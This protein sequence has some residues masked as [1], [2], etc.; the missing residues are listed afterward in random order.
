M[1]TLNEHLL[2][3]TIKNSNR[4]SKT[5]NLDLKVKF[6]SEI[7]RAKVHKTR[8][9]KIH[10]Y[11]FLQ[12][13]LLLYQNPWY[14][15]V[16]MWKFKHTQTSVHICMGIKTTNTDKSKRKKNMKNT[17]LQPHNRHLWYAHNNRQKNNP[18]QFFRIC[19]KN[20]I[21]ERKIIFVCGREKEMGG[22]ENKRFL[23]F[24]R[25]F[26]CRCYYQQQ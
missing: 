12:Q 19:R 17:M 20:K 11:S 14:L 2:S 25:M 26:V 24:F 7:N 21:K 5:I 10:E 13:T 9:I 22:V 3:I 23:C 4:S 1:H 18:K 6:S 15:H 8:K 16:Q